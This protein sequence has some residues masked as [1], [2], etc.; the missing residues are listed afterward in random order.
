MTESQSVRILI[1]TADAGA[2]HRS[3]A[4]ALDGALRARYGDRVVTAIVNPLHEPHAPM[5]FRLA[6][7]NYLNRVQ[8]TPTLYQLQHEATDSPLSAAIFSLSA[9]LLL[10]RTM[11]RLLVRWQPDVVVSVYMLY[12][13]AVAQ[14]A[15]PGP[16]DSTYHRHHRPRFH[17]PCSLVLAA[18]YALRGVVGGRAAQ[19]PHLR[20]GRR[21][22]RDRR[23]PCG[24][25]LWST[26]GPGQHV[27]SGVGLGGRY[28]GHS[29]DERRRRHRSW[30]TWRLQLMQPACLRSWLWSSVVTKNW[31]SICA[32]A[33]R[34]PTHIYGF[35]REV[36]T[37]MH[38]S[39]IVLTKAGGLS[40]SEA[41]AAGLPII[42]HSAIQG[43]ETGNVEHVVEHGAV[44]APTSAEVVRTLRRWLVQDRR[45]GDA[46]PTRREHWGAR[47]RPMMW[48]AWPSMRDTR[49]RGKCGRPRRRPG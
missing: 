20:H 15:P 11:T 26:D 36:P 46:T 5:A 22:Y 45:S 21:A 31:K 25:A 7:E 34:N 19:S 33:W 2:G 6:E 9:R 43:Q 14:P 3:A 4:N 30:P 1:L 37:L 17:R 24:S 49:R 39:D 10:T 29:A 8:A 40:V 12:S 41:L 32:V 28:A 44:W 48:L 38:A 13:E 27:A 16:P 47:R 23:H 35:T 18:R 42:L